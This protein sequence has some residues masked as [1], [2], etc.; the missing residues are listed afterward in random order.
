MTPYEYTGIQAEVLP[1]EE[2][3]KLMTGYFVADE[4]ELYSILENLSS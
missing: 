2:K 4:K 1:E 3:N